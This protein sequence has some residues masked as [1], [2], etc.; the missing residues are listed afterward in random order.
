MRKPYNQILRHPSCC[1]AFFGERPPN[2]RLTMRI[3]LFSLTLPCVGAALLC[4]ANVSLAQTS[5]P[6][7]SSEATTQ[8]IVIEDK[9]TRVNELR[10]RGMTQSIT[11]APPSDSAA[12]KAYQVNPKDSNRDTS[13]QG[14]SS[15]RVMGF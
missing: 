4:V 1:P 14:R 2:C 8:V 5:A 13:T 3:P 6:A 12:W 15:W 11:V 7:T 9:A 10:V